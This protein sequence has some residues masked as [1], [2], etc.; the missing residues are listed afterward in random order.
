[1]TGVRAG[2][3][4]RQKLFSFALSQGYTLY[5]HG[6]LGAP[7]WCDFVFSKVRAVI[8]G[9][10]RLIYT[11]SAPLSAE[12]QKFVQTV[13][14]CPVRQGYGLTETCAAS[15]LSQLCDNTISQVGPPSLGTVCRLADWEEG[16]YRNSDLVNPS[17]RMRRGEVLIG[18]PQVCQGYWVDPKNPDTEIV[19]K[20]NSD[21]V[22][23][24]GIRYFRTGDIGQITHDGNLQI[25][26]R[27]KDLFKGPQGEYVSLSKVESI[28]KLSQYVE[29]PMVY[30][31]TGAAHVICIVSPNEKEVRVFAARS[32]IAETSMV[33]LCKDKRV[34][35]E[36]LKSILEK[37]R[38]HRLA[39]FEMPVKVLLT[40]GQDGAPAWT[41]ENDLLTAAM[42]LKRPAIARRY[43]DELAQLYA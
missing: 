38:E 17:I 24:G 32:G 40:P 21:F 10:V 22:T 5:D 1:V 39:A 25:I 43:K 20:N 41:P 18:G 4:F 14:K 33:A 16:G 30:G 31:H 8:G 29:M 6:R 28:A 2:G 9:R 42:K 19:E 12:I 34:I 27:K 36:V 15:F 11:G 35:D 3:A 13:F 26:D 23:L 37:C 7:W